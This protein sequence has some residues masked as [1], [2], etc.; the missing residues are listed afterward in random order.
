MS[1]VALISAALS[2]A[3]VLALRARLPGAAFVLYIFKDVYVV[4]LIEIFWSYANTVFPIRTARW[5]YGLFCVMGSGGGAAMNLVSGRIAQAS[6]G[7]AFA[8]ALVGRSDPG[9]GTLVA[10]FALVPVLVLLAAVAG[11]AHRIAPRV[12]RPE[13]KAEDHSYTEG[14]RLVRASRYLTLMLALIALSQLTIT[15][16]DYQFNVG[17]ELYEPDTDRR[18]ALMGYVAA[19]F[20]SGA[21]IL[22]LGTGVI[23]T[24]VGVRRVLPSIPGLLGAT[25][26]AFLVAPHVA[27]L[28][29]A[30]VL[31][32]VLDY[33]L[34]RASKELLYIPLEYA[35]KTQGKAVIDMLTY[36]VAKGAASLLLLALVL[37]EAPRL[38]GVLTL[39]IIGIWVVVSVQLAR[40][41]PG[42]PGAPPTPGTS[43]SPATTR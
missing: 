9:S 36:R 12:A 23:L 38:V 1:V 41:Y 15:L 32:K 29:A 42:E 43:T 5:I 17:I 20:N 24:F 31:S 22:Q 39:G 16:V 19:A 14:L 34:F 11:L 26:L 4:V 25:L 2:A 8:Q 35:E 7:T 21:V 18:T 37:L 27:L 28:A 10:L 40:I 3:L 13:K 6:A 33:S 30:K